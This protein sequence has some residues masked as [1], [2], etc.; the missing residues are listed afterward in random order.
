M[1][2]YHAE[3]PDHFDKRRCVT[4]PYAADYFQENNNEAEGKEVE[5]M[6]NYV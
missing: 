2:I 4:R 6:I 3:N 1:E 5:Q